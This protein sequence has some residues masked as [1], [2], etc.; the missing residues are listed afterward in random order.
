MDHYADDLAALTAHLDLHDAVHVG[1]SAG[2]S[3][4]ALPDQDGAG[5]QVHGREGRPKA[6]DRGCGQFGEQRERAEQRD[7][8]D[9]HGHL[10]VEAEQGAPAGRGS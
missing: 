7:L 6:F 5:G 3:R 10:G 4:A 8:H 9:R 1:H 2:M